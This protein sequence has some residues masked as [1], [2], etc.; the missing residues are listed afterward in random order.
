[1]SDPISKLAEKLHEAMERI[2]P[3]G[4]VT[5]REMAPYRQEFFKK[6]VLELIS[7][8]DTI[9]E[10]VLSISQPQQNRLGRHISRTDGYEQ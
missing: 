1:M 8:R 4:D 9:L 5:W 10:A 7:E 3:T 2:D 6:C